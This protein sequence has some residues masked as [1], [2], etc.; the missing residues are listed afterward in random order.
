M[1]VFGNLVGDDPSDWWTSTSVI[2]NLHKMLIDVTI[3]TQFSMIVNCKLS[4]I[5]SFL[6]QI[7]CWGTILKSGKG[8]HKLLIAH[9]SKHSASFCEVH[10]GRT[11][12]K[13]MYS[14]LSKFYRGDPHWFQT[15]TIIKS[16]GSPDSSHHVH[17]TTWCLLLPLLFKATES[18]MHL[19]AANFHNLVF[20]LVK[21]IWPFW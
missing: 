12:Y 19:H 3:Y 6:P 7:S 16:L 20:T 11:R 17:L 14:F 1:A 2:C 10:W 4:T 21:L 13:V 18:I 9:T 8:L 5:I 15:G